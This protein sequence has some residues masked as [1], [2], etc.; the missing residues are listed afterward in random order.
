MI[1]HKRTEASRWDS[2]FWFAQISVCDALSASW[3]WYGSS[4]WLPGFYKYEN[5]CL[6]Y[7]GTQLFIYKVLNPSSCCYISYVPQPLSSHDQTA[8][9]SDGQLKILQLQLSFDHRKHRAGPVLIAYWAV[10]QINDSITWPWNTATYRFYWS[11]KCLME[12]ISTSAFHTT[13]YEVISRGYNSY[14][15]KLIGGEIDWGRLGSLKWPD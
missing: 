5:E 14:P 12:S 15:P 7:V 1:G 13:I 11:Q 2:P 4:F 8:V 9:S 3:R 10:K 6:R